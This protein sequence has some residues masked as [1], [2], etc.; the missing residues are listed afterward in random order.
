MTSSELTGGTGFTY[1]DAVTAHYLAA[2]VDGTT[3]GAL[4][5]RIVQRVAQQQA[6]FGE[7]LD[8]VIVDAAS[9][10]DT[11]VM[12][13]SLQVKRSLTISDA[14]SNSDFREVIQRAW[15]TLQKTSFREQVDRVGAVTGT[16]AEETSRALTTVC[17]WARSSDTN[18][19]FMQRFVDGANASATHRAVTEA[20][21]MV[22]TG[23]DIPL[24]DAQLH[25][26]LSHLI[27][28]RFDF[29]HAGSTHE[30]AA[31]AN[32]ARTLVSGQV[33][34]AADFWN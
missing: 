13:L 5:G 1:E 8:D 25:R 30:A 28:I 27:L 31:I 9:L 33:A 19:V 16:V 7:P 4:G 17:E 12:R 32:A 21:R 2:M 23:I 3:A 22:A 29:L 18:E 20:V 24:S 26:L 34:R 15:Q 10:T 6:D 14:Q 11:T